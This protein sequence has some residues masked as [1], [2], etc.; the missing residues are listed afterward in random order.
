MT[1]NINMRRYADMRPNQ[2]QKSVKIVEDADIIKMD[3]IVLE[4]H[5]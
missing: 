2:Q 4:I 5:E 1:G 3:E